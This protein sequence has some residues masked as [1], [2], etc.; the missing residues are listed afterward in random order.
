MNWLG[1]VVTIGTLIVMLSG[2]V[3]QVYALREQVKENA[4]AISIF[5]LDKIQ[6]TLN[7]LEKKQD[8]QGRLDAEDQQQKDEL[9]R[10]KKALM[11]E[12]YKICR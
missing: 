10:I 8:K 2:G 1:S 9:E 4:K 7:H 3:W 6:K 5:T 12:V 11:C